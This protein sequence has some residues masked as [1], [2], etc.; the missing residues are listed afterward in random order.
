MMIVEPVT[1]LPFG[2]DAGRYRGGHVRFVC[3]RREYGT[4][5][6]WR[7]TRG[8]PPR[9]AWWRI[10]AGRVM[11]AGLPVSMLAKGT[12]VPGDSTAT[13]RFQGGPATVPATLKTAS[14][15][16]TKRMNCQRNERTTVNSVAEAVEGYSRIRRRSARA[17]PSR[18]RWWTGSSS[19]LQT[20]R[21]RP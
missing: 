14:C 6:S 4:P 9:F 20:E 15:R 18:L 7:A 11:T 13:A 17:G 3:A 12:A 16:R 19:T 21:R 2:R 8:G 10:V 1:S 5:D